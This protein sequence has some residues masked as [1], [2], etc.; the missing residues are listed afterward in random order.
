MSYVNYLKKGFEVLKLNRKVIS[1]LSKDRE[2]TKWGVVTII[3]VNLTISFFLAFLITILTLG[4]GIFFSW[5]IVLVLPIVGLIGAYIGVGI[6][7]LLAKL[8]GGK[9]T[10][11]GLF[12][13]LAMANM[14]YILSFIPLI[15]YLLFIWYLVVSVVTISETQKIS[16]GKAVAV[17]L[18]PII[19]SFII[20]IIF[21]IFLVEFIIGSGNNPITKV[22]PV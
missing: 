18:I 20:I 4:L 2:A 14:I 22:V 10:Y 5:I 16:P 21:M 3:L 8:F 9:G 13:P 15:N 1:A 12:R 7:Y 17:I 11:M 19:I 6:F